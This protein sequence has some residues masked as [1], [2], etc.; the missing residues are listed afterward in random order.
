M[1]S[2]AL[3]ILLT[4]G[5]VVQLN[6]VPWMIQTIS[7]D[8]HV[9][10]SSQRDGIPQH[11]HLTLDALRAALQHT[12]TPRP[13]DLNRDDPKMAVRLAVAA[14]KLAVIKEVLS[15]GGAAGSV[16]A[17]S[18]K[19]GVARS[20]LYGWLREWHTS[21]S[22]LRVARSDQGKS[23]LPAAVRDLITQG[24]EQHYLSPE[25]PRL[26]T[27]VSE[28][29]RQCQAAGVRPPSTSS[30]YLQ[31]RALSTE[32]KLQRKYGA[33]AARQVRPSGRGEVGAYPLDLVEIDHWIV[34]LMLVHS[35][36]RTPIGRAYLTLILDT[37]SRMVLG[38]Y[39]S[40]DP[41]DVYAVGRACLNAWL[42]KDG[43]LIRL[44]VPGEWPCHGVPYRLR[45]DR[46]KEFESRMLSDLALKHNVQLVPARPHHPRDKAHVERLFGTLAGMV[47]ELPGTTFS[48][49]EQRGTYDS[50]AR[51]VLTLREFERTLIDHIV[52]GYH[53]EQ[54]TTLNTTP[55]KY[56]QKSLDQGKPRRWV[57]DPEALRLDV[58]PQINGGRK[59]HSDGVTL[60]GL[61]YQD[62][63]LRMLIGSGLKYVIK[64]DPSDLSSVWLHNG[65]RY[66]RLT[67]SNPGWPPVSLREYQAAR[68]QQKQSLDPDDNDA[69]M[70]LISR[71]RQHIGEATAATR[72]AR[73]PAGARR[74][75]RASEQARETAEHHQTLPG[76]V[77]PLEVPP[78]NS[79]WDG[80]V[81]IEDWSEI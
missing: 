3:P 30:V 26:K 75:K 53:R 48:N 16:R 36:D 46:A 60:F 32:Q 54:H 34:H 42:P 8:Q 37:A 35:Q 61:R 67:Y 73:R 25:R 29:R 41:P 77:A 63:A 70:A 79:P 64:Y 56:F 71:Q 6:N 57:L 49:V 33:E 1:K 69:I 24:I 31:I 44:D 45:P 58:L 40:L 4:A 10:L 7:D 68:K 47:H 38:Y 9:W 52:N 76:V 59:V 80:T 72:A 23:R 5:T 28:I 12:P 21:T 66:I 43:T 22:L 27:V 65:E 50:D 78:V 55:L 62:D 81:V 2:P 17:V 15:L 11:Q 74:A 39:L 19:T 51:A 14:R 18:Q 13:Q 20:T